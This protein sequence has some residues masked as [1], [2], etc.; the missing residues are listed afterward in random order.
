MNNYL[1]SKI[2]KIFVF[3]KKYVQ[4]CF[5]LSL[6]S[7]MQMSYA[8]VNQNN[9]IKFGQHLAFACMSC[10]ASS[11]VPNLHGMPYSMLKQKIEDYASGANKATIMHQLA[12]GY[13]TEQI[14]AIARYFS[15]VNI[16]NK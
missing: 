6:L 7:F 8:Q 5:G 1:L 4:L 13:S 10:H 16:K 3:V 11:Q 2:F 12:K 9:Q 14:E 15:S